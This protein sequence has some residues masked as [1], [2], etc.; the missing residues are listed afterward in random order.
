MAPGLG[1]ASDQRQHFG[2]GTGQ[3][4]GGNGTGCTGA[5]LG[6]GAAVQHGLEGTG[7]AVKEQHAPLMGGQ[8]LFAVVV[9]HGDD[10]GS[11][12]PGYR[13]RHIAHDVPRGQR[14]DGAQVLHCPALLQLGQT[15]PHQAD[16]PGRG[17]PPEDLLPFNDLHRFAL[18]LL[19]CRP[20]GGAVWDIFYCYSITV[21]PG[22]VSPG[23][24]KAPVRAD[25]RRIFPKFPAGATLPPGPGLPGASP[26]WGRCDGSGAAGRPLQKGRPS[27]S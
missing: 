22:I 14:G 2:I 5:D 27:A 13:R 19:V 16:A 4:I 18:P 8:T 23:N 26:G 15:V 1:A 6:D 7:F 12:C 21:R 10:L 11:E 17:Q 3:Q 9:E 25:R 20:E 24:K